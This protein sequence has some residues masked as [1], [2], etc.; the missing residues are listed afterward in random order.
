MT[1][2]ISLML[3]AAA[4]IALASPATA[5]PHGVK[6]G[7]LTCHVHS[8]WGFIVGSSK[9]MDC[10][11]RPN[12]HQEDHYEGSISKFG[13]DIGYTDS[14]TIIWDVVAPSSDVR[15]GAL[16][17]DYA[18]AT[19]SATVGAG[20]GANVLLGGLDKSIALQPVSVM[21]NTGLD[22]AAGVGAISLRADDEPAHV[23]QTATAL[24]PSPPPPPVA[25]ARATPR[26]ITPRRRHIAHRARKHCTCH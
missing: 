1:R 3:G 6:V 14:G 12:G 17:G 26:P 25:V 11:Y 18:G 16:Q 19:A 24:P 5:A 13:V 9:D 15:P 22:I 20:I 23:A 10:S 7:I 2:R 4:I 8:G 21:G